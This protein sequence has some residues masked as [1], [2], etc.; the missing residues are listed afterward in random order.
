MATM[1]R[2]FSIEDDYGTPIHFEKDGVFLV[3]PN[4]IQVEDKILRRNR[5]FNNNLHLIVQVNPKLI[6]IPED[7]EEAIRKLYSNLP[8]TA[9][10]NKNE[11]VD[12]DRNITTT[13]IKAEYRE[14]VRKFMEETYID[15]PI[16]LIECLKLGVSMQASTITSFQVDP[17]AGTPYSINP[18]LERYELA[19]KKAIDKGFVLR[20]GIQKR[21]NQMKGF[22]V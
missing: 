7:V 11:V 18:Y 14:K 17:R 21:K 20:R 12:Y 2:I 15:L 22:M 10:G 5:H 13:E 3:N 6:T 4:T 16:Q 9:A 1:M 8:G 19:I